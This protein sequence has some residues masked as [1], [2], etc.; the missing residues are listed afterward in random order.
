MSPRLV[1]HTRAFSEYSSELTLVKFD[2]ATFRTRQPSWAVNLNLVFALT[3]GSVKTYMKQK[4]DNSLP[5]LLFTIHLMA[6]DLVVKIPTLNCSSEAIRTEWLPCMSGALARSLE[7]SYGSGRGV[8]RPSSTAMDTTGAL[9][10]SWI[11]FPS[12]A[13]TLCSENFSCEGTSRAYA[14]TEPEFVP[15]HI[16]G[17]WCVPEKQR[18]NNAVNQVAYS[19]PNWTG[20]FSISINVCLKSLESHL[21]KQA[22]F[23]LSFQKNKWKR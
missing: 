14:Y 16:V 9:C 5:I 19:M 4:N 22:W 18:K 23:D 12:R 15:A 10:M 13:S 21:Q 20:F 7:T 6:V 17:P 11:S 3:L 8:P 2:S 1:R